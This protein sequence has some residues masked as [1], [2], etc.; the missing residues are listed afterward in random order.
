MPV[1]LYGQSANMLEICKFAKDMNLRVIEDAAQG[2]G[3]EYR[4]KHVGTYGDCSI[5]SFYGN[6]TITCGEG[7]VVLTDSKE[8]YEKCG[9]L[10]NHGRPERGTFIHEQIGFNFAFTEMQ[11]AIGIS[12]LNKLG[13]IISK[14][15]KIRNRYLAG[16]ET[17][18]EIFK[19]HP[20]SKPVHWFTSLKTD[21]KEKLSRYLKSKNIGTRNFF[22]PLHKQ[23]C[24]LNNSELVVCGGPQS[25][26]NSTNAYNLG[27]SL[28]SSYNLSE[29]DQDR[30]IREVK[31]FYEE[32]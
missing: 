8:I 25:Y 14:K 24:Y 11:A 27:L 31:K 15:E 12:Q 30:V 23:P 20:D 13:D 4:G 17:V 16:L 19:N 26:K 3:V 7:G 18:V 22:Y 2:V 32:N 10:K 28:P 29:D 1:H 6:K 21:K 9:I 5:L